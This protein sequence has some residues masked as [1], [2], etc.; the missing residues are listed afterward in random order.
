MYGCIIYIKINVLLLCVIILC[1]GTCKKKINHL[2]ENEDKIITIYY[3]TRLMTSIRSV[4]RVPSIRAESTIY[5]RKGI[6][7]QLIFYYCL[8]YQTPQSRWKHARGVLGCK[9]R[10]IYAIQLTAKLRDDLRGSGY[11][12]WYYRLADC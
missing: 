1:L 7:W 10:G 6:F 2:H 5:A 8:V 12:W 4:A 3:L 9:F 11:Y